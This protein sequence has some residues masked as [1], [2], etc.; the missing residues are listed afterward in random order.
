MYHSVYSIEVFVFAS[1]WMR[2]QT[3]SNMLGNHKCPI[4]IKWRL[5]F[6]ARWQFAC[7]YHQWGVTDLSITFDWQCAAILV[8]FF[9]CASFRFRYISI[10]FYLYFDL[11]LNFKC[12]EEIDLIAVYVLV[13]FFI[14]VIHLVFFFAFAIYIFHWN[15]WVHI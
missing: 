12:E 14:V 1:I 9:L 15:C 4:G 8:L 7:K 2:W 11:Y 6:D 3:E 5:I 13:V 10:R